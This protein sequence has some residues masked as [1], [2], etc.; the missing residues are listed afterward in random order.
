MRAVARE[1]EKYGIR[2]NAVLQAVWTPMI[3]GYWENLETENVGGH[4]V[5]MN[6]RVCLGEK[7][8][9][10]E[11]DLVPVLAFLVSDASRWITGQL[12]PINGGLSLGR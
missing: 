10:V 7:F 3:D 1:W 9:D 12:V 11:I 4:D 2:V 6:D 8:G 5:F